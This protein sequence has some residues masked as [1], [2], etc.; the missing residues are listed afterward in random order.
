[1]YRFSILCTFLAGLLW[2]GPLWAD[3]HEQ[4]VA[5]HNANAGQQAPGAAWGQ[6]SLSLGFTA[7]GLFGRCGEPPVHFPFA[8]RVVIKTFFARFDG[9]CDDLSDRPCAGR[10]MQISERCTADDVHYQLT[11]TQG[12][13][14]LRARVRI[15]FDPSAEANC[16]DVDEVASGY[17]YSHVP[18]NFSANPGIEGT[19][20]LTSESANIHQITHSKMFELDGDRVKISK[21]KRTGGGTT[22]V[23]SACLFQ[24]NFCPSVLRLEEAR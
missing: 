19:F 24:N 13:D 9:V 14:Y 1:M 16:D 18:G 22:R 17:M 8:H 23:S 20:D 6:G 5:G 3:Q 4:P 15:C 10:L 12:V 2:Q 11:E 21:R 7:E